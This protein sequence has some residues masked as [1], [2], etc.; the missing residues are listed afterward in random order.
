MIEDVILAALAP[1]FAPTPLIIANENGPRPAGLYGTIRIE[2][3]HRL[4]SHTGPLA[5][6]EPNGTRTVSAHRTGMLE[7]QM[8]GAAAYDTLD[9]GVQKF[10][11]DEN[12]ERF[13]AAGIVF[14]AVHDVENLPV[15]RNA[16]QFDPRAV[17]E[18]PFS[19]TRATSES[20][21]WID[22]VEGEATIEG[23]IAS[24]SITT[25]FGVTIVDNP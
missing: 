14:G 12:L 1:V 7:L 9:L 10:D 20:V 5:E 24:V 22:T 19:Y 15:L 8:F 3:M 25:P 13:E 17:V 18:I 6:G 4:P 16:S 21:S 11:H 23:E 2:S